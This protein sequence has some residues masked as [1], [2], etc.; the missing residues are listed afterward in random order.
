MATAVGTAPKWT[1]LNAVH[2]ALGAR[3]VEFAGWDMPVE[4]SGITDEHIAVRTRA[5]LFDV[6][7]MGEIDIRGPGAL[8]LVQHV[9]SNDASHL[10]IGQAHYSALMY[11][12]G[13][14]VDDCLV[15]RFA[16]N[17]FFL[18]V[19]ASNVDKDFAW[20]TEHN[21]FNADARNVSA[22]YSQ[23]ALQGPRA[24]A[25]V[26]KVTDADLGSLKYYWFT[27]ATV[28]GVPGMLARTGYTGEDGFEFYFAPEKSE[29]VWNALMDV[30]KPEGLIPAGLGARNTLR[31]E[32]GMAL[33]GHELDEDT[34]LL[35]ANLGWITKIEKGEF[36]GREALAHQKEQGTRKKL[37]G[38][39]MS[40]RAP[41]RD[42]YPVWSKDG[43]EQIGRVTSGSPAPFL[44]KNIGMA[45]VSREGLA[46]AIE[47]GQDIEIEIRGRR[48]PA[49]VVQLP[50]Y[51]RHR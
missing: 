4:Y 34:T 49:R 18:C 43:N 9:T 20:I 5:G 42:G 1:A 14:A 33:Y 3:M 8:A 23:L 16:E 38:F 47:P 13:S 7:H 29:H 36:L 15:H 48:A 32:A 37:I 31:L 51:K 30:G 35:E 12:N 2:R 40:D 19:N 10:K 39:E 50:F 6:S 24:L 11:P 25:I 26:S 44:K 22:E 21:R 17:H 41:A 27:Q 45:Y 46:R 28:A